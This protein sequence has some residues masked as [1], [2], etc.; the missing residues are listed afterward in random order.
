MTAK[1]LYRKFSFN[2]DDE[3][4]TLKQWKDYY[5]M[6]RKDEKGSDELAEINEEL[7][8]AKDSSNFDKHAIAALF[9]KRALV[10]KQENKIEDAISDYKEA[11][12]IDET[13]FHAAYQI[14][15]CLSLLDKHEEALEWYTISLNKD[16]GT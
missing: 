5:L 3:K 12:K 15:N 7:K 6:A 1:S 13:L 14:A 11:L 10:K 2:D 9:C 8:M 4:S 16:C